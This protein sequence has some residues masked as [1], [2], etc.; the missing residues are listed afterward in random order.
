[1][2]SPD[3]PPSIATDV[4]DDGLRRYGVEADGAAFEASPIAERYAEILEAAI[5]SGPLPGLLAYMA[6]AVIAILFYLGIRFRAPLPG[7][8]RGHRQR[9]RGLRGGGSDP[10]AVAIETPKR[11]IL[12]VINL[13]FWAGAEIQLRNLAIGLR[14]LGHDVTLVA[15]E[16]ITSHAAD[17]EKAGVKL[18]SLGARDRVG[19]LRALPALVR[20]ARKAEIVHCTGWDASLWG[21][22]AAIMARRPV[23]V[24]E[25]AGDRSL[26]VSKR[27][28]P[29]S[30][31][32]AF[33][34]R[35]LDRA[36]NA[37]VVV[38]SAQ[39]RQLEAEGVRPDSIVLIPNG[40]PV[41]ELRDRAGNGCDRSALG[42]PPEATVIM[43]VARFA[44]PKCQAATLRLVARL[45]ERFGD[46]RAVFVGD[47]ETED[48]VRRQAAGMGADWAVFLGSRDD[49]P[50][51]LRSADLAV[52]PSKAEGL[53]MSL[54]EAI[55]VGTPVVATDVGDVR[56]LLDVNGGG[57]C[58][59]KE[60]EDAFAAACARVLADP[61]LH[62]R[63][64]EEG[65]ARVGDFD[66]ARMVERYSC[67]LE[68]AINSRPASSLR[69][70]LALES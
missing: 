67:L 36:T 55:A 63:L 48:P 30:R 3:G 22:L 10:G 11:R 7:S 40:V 12:L 42:I 56:W 64:R 53:P 16:D 47:G 33:H 37:T 23:V 28:A 15:V 25:H 21:R 41:E 35:A 1:M 46:V 19:K 31:M 38:S 49:V 69:D 13:L 50:A 34:N 51:L 20:A 57:L 14:K 2:P 44:P 54:I 60:D 29:R 61:G 32:I 9:L 39:P 18:Q 66:A 4:G 8:D 70:E 43:H 52:L 58:V 68:A 26:Q 6:P 27:G 45:R 62:Q 24:T 5:V 65:L 17:L 59:A